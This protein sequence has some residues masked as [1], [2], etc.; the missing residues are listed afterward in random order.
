M[1][2][3]VMN[4]FVICAIFLSVFNLF[5]DTLI[6]RGPD[7]G[8]LY[9]IGPTVTQPFAIYH[10][11]D[12]GETATC[13]DSTYNMGGVP[14]LNICADLT[15]GAIYGSTMEEALYIS[16]DHGQEGS[17]IL[18]SG[19]IT[20]IQSGRAEG[21]IY[22]NI[23]QHS[24]DYGVSFINHSINGYFGSI[25]TYEI[26]NE[27]NVGYALVSEYGILDSLWFL[28]SYNDFDD[29][30]I[31][32]VFND[33]L[34]NNI[35]TRGFSNGELYLF[36][37]HSSYGRTL[38]HSDDYGE[39]W[40]LKNT[41]NC[42][43]LPIT[44]IVGGN[45]PGEL[46]MNV[47]YYQLMGTIKRTYIY[48]S[49]DYGETF[50]IYNPFSY[51]NEPYFADFIATP[52]SGHAPL[53]VQF[54]DI[55][56]GLNNQEWQWDF[57]GDGEIDSFEQN[58]EYTYEEPGVYIVSLTIFWVGQSE[59]TASQE[60]IVTDGSGTSNN[61]LE[62]PIYELNNYP[63]P[64]NPTTTISFDLPKNI[65]NARIEIFNIKGQMIN[66]IKITDPSLIGNQIT[67]DGSDINHS[68][69][70]S[71]I[72]LYQIKSNE[73]LSKMKKMVLLK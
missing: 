65:V 54:T 5:A 8:E 64:F 1:K 73:Y 25:K 63:N 11:T 34:G 33:F 13:M 12:F 53:T 45:Q 42:P 23:S 26:D 55:S 35:L 37:Y 60:I 52:D 3:L 38:L 20:R 51:G 59:M 36:R 57:D 46:F 70:S 47:K 16:Y 72:Y 2:R 27:D 21:H 10:S 40:E 44:S 69:V 58:P 17:W 43:N 49:L 56:S 31:Q 61:E 68:Q 41:F 66:K 30:E 50:T 48:H 19:G 29:L 39:T 9:F 32:Y 4:L 14:I 22:D 71:G 28:I 7:I 24:E 62:I 67:W 6:T 15:A 18:R